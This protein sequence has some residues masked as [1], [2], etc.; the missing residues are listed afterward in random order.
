[1]AVWRKRLTKHK[2]AISTEN[3]ANLD[4]LTLLALTHCVGASMS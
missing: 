2:L 4:G 3:C 1:M